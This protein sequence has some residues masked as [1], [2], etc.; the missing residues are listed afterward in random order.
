[1]S[2]EL[3]ASAL[4]DAG[5]EVHTFSSVFDVTT[6]FEAV[7]PHCIVI[8]LN[9]PALK[10]DTVVDVLRRNATH[11]CPIVL[12]SAAA[13]PELRQRALACGADAF[14]RKTQDIA[15]LVRAVRTQMNK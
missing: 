14:V 4:E 13:E 10:G 6:R 11:R 8:D 9:M 3:V 1:M 12:Y 2:L 7:R 5:F 15:P